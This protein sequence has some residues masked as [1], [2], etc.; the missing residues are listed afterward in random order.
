[1]TGS[2]NERELWS[3]VR[4]QIHKKG[5]GAEIPLLIAR[6]F[7][8]RFIP[9]VRIWLYDLAF[10][11]GIDAKT[12]NVWEDCKKVFSRNHSGSNYSKDALEFSRVAYEESLAS[13]MSET[14]QNGE[15]TALANA[16]W[17]SNLITQQEPSPILKAMAII[18]EAERQSVEDFNNAVTLL[19]TENKPRL[20]TLL[21]GKLDHGRFI[22]SEWK[23][24]L[25][26]TLTK[27]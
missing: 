13:W 26:S 2:V 15:N 12:L 21:Q 20:K 16:I 14:I 11:R 1:M 7:E 22:G 19:K 24:R 9:E 27:L 25:K 3:W 23:E 17:A 6:K 10:K 5:A 18:A 8:G 4:E